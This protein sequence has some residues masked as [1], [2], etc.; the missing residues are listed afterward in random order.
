M[1]NQQLTQL[2]RQELPGILRRDPALRE[3]VVSL[4]RERYADKGETESRF[5]RMLDEL[6]RDREESTRKWEANQQALRELRDEQNR[7][8]EEQNRKWEANQQALREL[9]EAQQQ[10]LRDFR[11]EQER[12]WEE[13]NRK[14]EENAARHDRTLAAIEAQAKEHRQ[15]LGAIGARWGIYTEASFRN[16]LRGILQDSFGVEVL[17]I[18]E[19][20]DTG[21]VFGRPDQIE[22]DVLITNGTVI[23]CEIKSAM[24][25]ADVYTFERKVAFYE[26]LHQRPVHRRIVI[27]PMI[28]EAARAAAQTLG[29]EVYSYADEVAPVVLE[30]V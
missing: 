6:R 1:E 27:S 20:D 19:W 18:T 29:I 30:G 9:R 10:E 28:Y 25:K 4:T 2:I 15:S 26:K 5:D 17:N 11:E 14:W 13:Q 24:S 12:K 8:W 22:L 16:G 21:A 7:K 23:A 3:W